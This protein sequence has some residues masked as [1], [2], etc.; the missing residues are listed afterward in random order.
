M[1]VCMCVCVCVCVSDQEVLGDG[2]AK[3]VEESIKQLLNLIVNRRLDWQSGDCD[4]VHTNSTAEERERERACVS[5]CAV[6]LYQ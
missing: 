5:V 6:A 2:V 3:G 4:A 1:C